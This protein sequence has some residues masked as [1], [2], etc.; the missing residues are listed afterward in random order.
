MESPLAGV[1][2]ERLRDSDGHAAR[3]LAASVAAAVRIALDQWARPAGAATS[4]LLVPTG[5][6]A[7]L[8]RRA[9]APLAPALDAAASARNE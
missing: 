6:L 7:D 3:V 9:L 5:S 1:I 8:L 4:G 2:A